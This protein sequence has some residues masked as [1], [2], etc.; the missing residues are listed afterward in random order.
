MAVLTVALPGKADSGSIAV[1]AVVQAP[2]PTTFPTITTPTNGEQVTQEQLT[3][4]GLCSPGLTVVI[5]DDQLVSG[6]AACSSNGSFS[7]AVSLASGSNPLAAYHVDGL[8]QRG[9]SSPTIAVV[10]QP[11]ATGQSAAAASQSTT[12]AAKSRPTTAVPTVASAFRIT[13]PV[14][15]AAVQPGQTIT[16]Q[17]NLENGAA[18]YAVQTDWG[19]R[20]QVLLS[21]AEAG[22][23]T[24]QHSYV[25]AGRYIIKLTASDTTGATT[26]YQTTLAV[27]NGITP[28][29]ATS[30]PVAKSAAVVP[31]Y[32]LLILWPVF[33]V[34]CIAVASFWLG[35]RYDRRRPAAQTP[36]PP[37]T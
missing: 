15:F 34:A 7:L 37:P 27:G 23:F 6:S 4:S 36:L 12:P 21:R 11:A 30:S 18:P 16:L 17:I 29:G 24:A 1:T 25:T 10:Y 5:T 19:D 28:T 32:K 9:P 13:A 33:L 3:V 8:G 14:E 35:E 31:A 2:A 22:P 20:S 26:Y